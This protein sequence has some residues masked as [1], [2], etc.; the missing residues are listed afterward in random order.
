MTLSSQ[1]RTIGLGALALILAV[2]AIVLFT[3]EEEVKASGPAVIVCID[4]TH[5]TEDVREDYL[6]DIETVVEEAADRRADFY[7]AACGENAT[8]NVNWPVRQEFDID[9]YSEALEK[10][11]L[12]NLQADAIKGV[13]KEIEKTSPEGGTPMAEMLAVAAG[14]C[15][16]AGGGCPIYLFTDGE[17]ADSILHLPREPVSDA[18]EDEYI[19]TYAGEV[20]DLSGSVVHFIGVGFGTK[21]GLVRINEGQKVAERLIRAANGTVGDWDVSL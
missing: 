1:Q 2:G 9:S 17:W 4:S 8:G 20:G 13:E 19:R 12:Q 18:Q 6:R 7:A 15:E 3:G 5:S 16:Q 21:V 14:K 10:E 11:A